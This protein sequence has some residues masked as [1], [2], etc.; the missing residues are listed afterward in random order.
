MAEPGA[1]VVSGA[2]EGMVDEVVLRHLVRQ[3]GGAVGVVYGREGKSRLRQ[4]LGGYNQAA[5]FS[6]WAVLVDLDEDFD[7]AALLRAVWLPTLSPRMCF[8]VAVR[9]IEA[10]LLADRDGIAQFLSVPPSRVPPD[11]D[12]LADPKRALVDLA[13]GSRRRAVREDL[14][15]RPG[16]GRAV[17]PVYTSEMITFVQ[18]HW[19]PDVAERASDS[20]RRCRARLAELLGG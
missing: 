4:R 18:Q 20:L 13:R 5:R 15:P 16:S 3:C 6:P 8:R 2:V 7:C 14:V 17:G 10:W 12:A 19:R 9:S 1:V 11:P